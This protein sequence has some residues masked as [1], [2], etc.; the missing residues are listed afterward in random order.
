VG[1]GCDVFASALGPFNLDTVDAI[2]ISEVGR[3]LN[4]L[5]KRKAD[6][7]G[8]RYVSGID[9]EFIGHDYCAEKSFFVSAEDSCVNQG[10]FMGMVHPNAE[11]H[12]AYS[13]AMARDLRAELGVSRWLEPVLATMMPA[14]ETRPAQ[15][16][17]PVLA[18]TMTPTHTPWLEATLAVTMT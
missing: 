3:A 12:R 11:G 18:T 6:E 7:F 10:D 8:W 15:W 4:D 2:V 14:A 9:L 13:Q 17:E 5:L 1:D 16:L